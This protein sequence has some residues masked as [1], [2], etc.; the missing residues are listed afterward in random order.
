MGEPMLTPALL[1]ES[2]SLKLPGARRDAPSGGAHQRCRYIRVLDIIPVGAVQATAVCRG[3]AAPRAG[4][5]L[6]AVV[7]KALDPPTLRP[8]QPHQRTV[9]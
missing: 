1:A 5:G 7:S 3:R 2:R 4:I 6:R 8:T 9:K